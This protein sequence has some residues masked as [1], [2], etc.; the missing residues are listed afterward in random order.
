MRDC[1]NWDKSDPFN[2]EEVKENIIKNLCK[3]GFVNGKDYITQLV[4]KIT[5]IAYG[6]QLVIRNKKKYLMKN[7]TLYLQQISEKKWD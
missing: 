2:F 6:K 5:S 7:Y 3:N 1:Q 4:P